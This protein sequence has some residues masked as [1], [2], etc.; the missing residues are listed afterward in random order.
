MVFG[1][2]VNNENCPVCFVMCASF[3]FLDVASGGGMFHFRWQGKHGDRHSQD[4]RPFRFS[5]ILLDLVFCPYH[6]LTL[7][8]TLSDEASLI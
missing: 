8:M 6:A 1:L 7:E 5:Q 4:L 3:M 2:N